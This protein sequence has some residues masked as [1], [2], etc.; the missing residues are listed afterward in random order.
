MNH[1]SKL[2]PWKLIS[3]KWPPMFLF[4]KLSNFLTFFITGQMVVFNVL[5][6]LI[7]EETHNLKMIKG[8]KLMK[9]PI[10]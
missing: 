10:I 8:T 4:F 3:Y 9:K 6:A 1:L 2:P 7:N 5:T